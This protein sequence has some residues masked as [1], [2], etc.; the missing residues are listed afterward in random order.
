MNFFEQVN[1]AADAV[2]GVS[3][4]GRLITNVGG[5]IST[6]SRLLMGPTQSVLLYGAELWVDDLGKKV[7]R[8]RFA[9]V[10]RHG[11]LGVASTYRN[12]SELTVIALALLAKER[13]A[14]YSCN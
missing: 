13:E 12:V 4:L 14:I 7:Y 6:R 1:S 9:R 10:Q 3:A 5:S 11:A 2:V 8:K